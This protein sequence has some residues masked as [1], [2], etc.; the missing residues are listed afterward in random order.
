MEKALILL[1]ILFF[2]LDNIRLKKRLKE[3][4]EMRELENYCY[5]ELL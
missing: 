4:Q 3:E 2:G 1:I 5:S